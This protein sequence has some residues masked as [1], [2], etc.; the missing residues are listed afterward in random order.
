MSSVC[1]CVCVCV[2]TFFT[3][4]L[5]CYTHFTAVYSENMLY[6]NICKK[7]VQIME[8]VRFGGAYGL[9]GVRVA[10]FITSDL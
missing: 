8:E 2:V 7:H 10:S 4:V 9:Y 5:S 3:A 1:V 6:A